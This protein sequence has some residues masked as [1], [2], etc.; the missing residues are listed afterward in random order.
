[1]KSVLLAAASVGAQQFVAR[2]FLAS[3][4]SGAVKAVAAA[5]PVVLRKVPALTIEWVT[6]LGAKRSV[7]ILLTGPLTRW[8]PPWLAAFAA[9]LG[10]AARLIWSVLS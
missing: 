1:M 6:P 3:A 8:A 2:R 5:A 9:G 4:A 7:Q 10:G